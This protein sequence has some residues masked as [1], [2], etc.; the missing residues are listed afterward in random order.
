MPVTADR[1]GQVQLKVACPAGGKACAGTVTLTLDAIATRLAVAA[2]ARAMPI[3]VIVAAGHAPFSAA[4][5]AAATVS[6]SLP[7][8]VA[9]LLARHRRLI[10]TAT[11]ETHG[12]AGQLASRSVQILVRAPAKPRSRKIRPRRHRPRK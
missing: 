8:A 7:G 4:A 10:L 9:K 12:G 1:H 6:I 3:P 5:G 11:V 2:R